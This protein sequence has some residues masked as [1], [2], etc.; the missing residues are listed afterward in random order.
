[1]ADCVEGRRKNCPAGRLRCQQRKARCHGHKKIG[2]NSK[3]AE[4]VD[5]RV[6]RGAG[7]SLLDHQNK[8]QRQRQPG[9]TAM[10]ARA[11]RV[12]ELE[13][14]SAMVRINGR[15]IVLSHSSQKLLMGHL[16]LSLMMARALRVAE[17]EEISAM[18]RIKSSDR[19]FYPT[20]AK[21]RLEWATWGL[22]RPRR[23]RTNPTSCLTATNR[24]RHCTQR[25]VATAVRSDRPCPT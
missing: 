5:D 6:E 4:V 9:D 18:V 22:S 23:F 7:C 24:G 15:S 3:E 8:L 10:M 21:R 12:A 20:Q 17:L 1:M 14:I 16:G 2:Q 25:T 19:L 11:L 13:E